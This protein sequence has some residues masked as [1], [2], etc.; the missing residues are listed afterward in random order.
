M[1][2]L[3]FNDLPALLPL[4]E[5]SSDAFIYAVPALL[6]TVMLS[7]RRVV[8]PMILGYLAVAFA[9]VVLLGIAV[10]YSEIAQASFKNRSGLGRVITQGMSFGFGLLIAALFYNFALYGM[11][12]AIVRGAR[13]AV[14]VMTAVGI[15]E[16]A[17]WFNV[18]L[19]TP[20]NTLVSGIIHASGAAY[21]QRLRM[22]AFEV[23]WASV[24]LTF[25]FPFA[26]VATSGS[27]AKMWVYVALVGWDVLLAQSRTG[28]LVFLCQALMLAWYHGRKRFDVVVPVIAAG[29]I[30]LLCL[31][32]S[33]RVVS[34]ASDDMANMVEYGTFTPMAG[35]VSNITRAAGI[36]AARE[37]FAEHKLLGVGLGQYGFY[38]RWH[39]RADDYRSY[40]VREYAT[41]RKDIWPPAYSVHARLLAETGI[42]GYGLWLGFILL[43]LA[44]SLG[45]ATN[46]TVD[47]QIAAVHMAAAMTLCGLL[48]VGASIDSFRFFGGWIAIGVAL[49]IPPLRARQA[50]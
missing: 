2:L 33:S 35:D 26:T 9:I 39:L 41:E 11:I 12:G 27:L 37:I 21:T 44:R 29:C 23:S 22:T 4:G 28:Y 47:R 15:L 24:I 49:G 25:F 5:M 45:I 10:N 36:H 1:L 34:E 46:A 31:A 19:L 43:L 16:F 50:A 40:E 42:I 6:G 3:A 8:L 18:P 7:G 32:T 13:V 14:L 48:L 38:Y 30:G 20:L 17:S